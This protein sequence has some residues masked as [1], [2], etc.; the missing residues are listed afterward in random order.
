MY[1]KYKLSFFL[2]L[3]FFGLHVIEICM[4]LNKHQK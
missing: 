4:I 2:F 3:F 1:N